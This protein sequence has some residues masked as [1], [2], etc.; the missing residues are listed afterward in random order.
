MRQ[1]CPAP[2]AAHI[3]PANAITP[4]RKLY[5]RYYVMIAGGWLQRQKVWA[6]RASRLSKPY[7]LDKRSTRSS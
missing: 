3:P 1:P 2:H 5:G 6:C 7:L 4:Q